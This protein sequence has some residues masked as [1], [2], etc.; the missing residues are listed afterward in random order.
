MFA[1]CDATPASAAALRSEP[2]KRREWRAGG[3]VWVGS[4]WGKGA[5]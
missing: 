4:E 3:L 5:A 2:G 1:S